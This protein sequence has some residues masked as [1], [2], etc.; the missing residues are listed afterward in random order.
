MDKKTCQKGGS[1]HPYGGEDNTPFKNRPD[2]RQ[3]GIQT[4]REKNQD[5]R[6]QADEFSK[7]GILEI[8]P[9]NAFRS[10]QYANNKKQQ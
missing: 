3:A 2:I 7:L 4:A 5:Q 9:A 8:D 6:H 10:G 1:G